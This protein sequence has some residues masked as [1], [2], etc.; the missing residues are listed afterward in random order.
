M[1]TNIEIKE[2]DLRSLAVQRTMK[3]K[4]SILKSGKVEPERIFILEPKSL[5]PDKKDKLKDS[6]VDLMLK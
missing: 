4:E 1:L 6:R 2:G 3:V 5:T